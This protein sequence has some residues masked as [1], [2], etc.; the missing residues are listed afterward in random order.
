MR[1]ELLLAALLGCSSCNVIEQPSGLI[2]RW[3]T[4]W[5]EVATEDDRRKAYDEISAAVRQHVAATSG[6]PQ[7]PTPQA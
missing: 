5:K 6:V 3:T 2:P 7:Q 4:A 1:A